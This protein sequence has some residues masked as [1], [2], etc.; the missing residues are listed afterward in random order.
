[1]I[2]GSPQI[3]QWPTYVRKIIFLD[4]GLGSE[5]FRQ[6]VNRSSTVCFMAPEGGEA[7]DKYGLFDPE[8]GSWGQLLVQII[9][10]RR[11]RQVIS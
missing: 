7:L 4:I 10:R 3:L 11:A 6:S 5:P 9:G 1:M 8:I 2:A